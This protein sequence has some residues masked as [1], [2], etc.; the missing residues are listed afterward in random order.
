MYLMQLAQA[1]QEVAREKRQR[2]ETSIADFEGLAQGEWLG[3]NDDGSGSV[4]Y[5][6]KKY[7]VV[8]DARKS[9]PAGTKV[10]LE[11]RKGYYIASWT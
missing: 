5:K 8:I 11:F 1:N 9:I 10:N 3:I 4:E 2:M 6:G 7:N